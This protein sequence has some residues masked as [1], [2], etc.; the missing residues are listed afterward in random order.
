MDN[1]YDDESRTLRWT[2]WKAAELLRLL[3]EHAGTLR[4]LHVE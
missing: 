2:G 1:G 3:H 4:Q